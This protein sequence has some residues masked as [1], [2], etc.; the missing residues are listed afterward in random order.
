MKKF[1]QSLKKSINLSNIDVI[2]KYR[3]SLPIFCDEILELLLPVPALHFEAH[4]WEEA[5]GT[6]IHLLV[7]L[8]V[9]VHVVV[10][11]DQLHQFVRIQTAIKVLATTSK[12]ENGS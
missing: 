9:V 4:V 12:G 7:V 3:Y 5:A 6:G 8:V 2:T 11:V 10:H 1:S